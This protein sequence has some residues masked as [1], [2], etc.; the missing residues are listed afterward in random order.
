MS[1]N[2]AKRQ[3]NLYR[4]EERKKKYNEI[5]RSLGLENSCKQMEKTLLI[6]K[7]LYIEASS[8]VTHD[9]IYD[10]QQK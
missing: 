3:K 10:I 8:S 4:T 1:N 9:D 2:S 6:L 5:F 7:L